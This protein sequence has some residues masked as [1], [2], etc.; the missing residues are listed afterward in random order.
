[1]NMKEFLNHTAK[2]MP[3]VLSQNV[4]GE[5]VLLDLKGENYFGLDEVGTRI[6]QL[7]QEDGNLQSV[8]EKMLE[9]YN[10]TEDQI[11]M[12]IEQL[13]TN[14]NEAGLIEIIKE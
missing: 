10:V 9:E 6:W 3:D 1:M 7:L 8:L 2:I 14:L 13:I 12:D 11:G 4:S 5:T